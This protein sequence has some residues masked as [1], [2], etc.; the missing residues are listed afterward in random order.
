MSSVDLKR[1]PGESELAY[2][3]RLGNMKN[4]GIIDMTWEELSGVFNENLR[5][6]GQW[7]TESAYRKK[8]ANLQHFKDEFGKDVPDDTE[9][10]DLKELRRELEREK[11]KIRDERNEYR[12]LIRD[13][14]RKESY[15]EQFLRSISEEAGRYALEYRPSNYTK[16]V[17]NNDMVIALTDLHAGIEIHNFWNDYDGE[18]LKYRLQH[19]LNRIFEIQERHNSENAFVVLSEL[20]SGLIHPGLRVQN[21]Q[22]LI[23]QFLMA[24]DYICDFISVL[25]GR[26]KEVNVYV[27]PGNH[28][29]INAKKEQDIAHENMDNLVIPFISARMQNYPNVHCFT[30]D[31]EQSMAVFPVRGINVVAVHGDKDAFSSVADNI[32]KLLRTR[33]DLIITGHLHTLALKTDADVKVVQSGCLSGSDEFAINHRLRGK[34]EQAICII[35]DEEGLD[36]IYDVKFD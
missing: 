4:A 9:A 15:R 31:I 23:D 7:W 11:V 33:V 20:I 8:Y 22:D 36:C 29:R 13:E 25:S 18:I 32:N 1:R 14:A 16:P 30:N 2:I 21:N 27:A 34:P 3:N 6:P 12:K 10:N 19:Y 24:T 17:S 35:S 28:S 5:E 26:F